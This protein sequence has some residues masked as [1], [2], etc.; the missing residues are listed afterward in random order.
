MKISRAMNIIFAV[1]AVLLFTQLTAHSAVYNLDGVVIPA[2]NL[3]QTVSE[4][5]A[6]QNYPIG[7]RLVIGDKTFRYCQI[8][9]TSNIADTSGFGLMVATDVSQTR[10]TGATLLVETATYDDSLSTEI[11]ICVSGAVRNQFQ[12]G[13]LTFIDI[14]NSY[15][16]WETIITASD[17]VV[18]ATGDTI[19][20][21]LAD[22]FP[23][24]AAKGDTIAIMPNLYSN[25]YTP[26]GSVVFESIV[27]MFTHFNPTEVD[28]NNYFCWLQ[29]WGPASPRFVDKKGGKHGQ[30]NVYYTGAGKVRAPD[31][32]T[33]GT[34]SDS[35]GTVITGT[36][37]DSLLGGTY[38]QIGNYMLRTTTTVNYVRPQKI[39]LTISP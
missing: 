16:M 15:E 2:A 8:G 28:Y 4:V 36:W 14:S 24:N 19:T 27:G 17:S 7:A 30:R 35:A 9:S 5:T 34:V 29:T 12:N 21:T 10:I 20:L 11:D 38:Q 13:Y 1:C 18:T 32:T 6:V 3:R 25:V 37:A 31:S 22:K 33:A 39:F 23:V 26:A